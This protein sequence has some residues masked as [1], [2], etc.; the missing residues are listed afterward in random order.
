MGKP[1]ALK[2]VFSTGSGTSKGLM[3][4]QSGCA[5]S[6]LFSPAEETTNL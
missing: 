1:T 5:E 3:F 6:M 2:T 4:L